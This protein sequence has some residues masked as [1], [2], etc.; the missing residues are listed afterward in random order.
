MEVDDQPEFGIRGVMVDAA[1]AYLPLVQLKQYVVLCRLYKLNHLHIQ[2]E[3]R[4]KH[5]IL[6][7]PTIDSPELCDYI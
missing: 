5:C 1:R 6:P 2:Y 7:R 3:L 4:Q